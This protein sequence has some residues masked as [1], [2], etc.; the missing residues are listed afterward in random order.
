MRVLE[1]FATAYDPATGEELW[2]DWAASYS[3]KG[4]PSKADLPGLFAK[5]I[6][7]FI[8]RLISADAYRISQVPG[9]RIFGMA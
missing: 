8:F 7:Y 1:W 6:E 5:E 3:F 4:G 2:S 9:P